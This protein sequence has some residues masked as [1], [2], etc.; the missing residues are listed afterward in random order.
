MQVRL[1]RGRLWTDADLNP[2]ATP[3]VI[4]TKQM[5]DAVWPGRDPLE[6]CLIVDD[7]ACAPVVGVIANFKRQQLREAPFM[8]Y[9]WPMGVGGDEPP[10]SPQI[11]VRMRGDF[12]RAEPLIRRLLLEIDPNQPYTTIVPYEQWVDPKARSWRLGASVLTAFGA[13]SLLLA[14]VGVYAVLSYVVASRTREIGVRAALGASPR[15]V[16][17]TV[18]V[19]GLLASLAGAGLG[20]ALALAMGAKVE[21]LLFN[22]S[23]RDPL[24]FGVAIGAVLLISLAATVLPGLRASRVDPLVALR[25]E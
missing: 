1:L 17:R 11:L 3:T 9:F 20:S 10:G 19:R 8:A 16:M 25:A 14:A 5:A 2:D 6:Q 21:G 18:V 7:R 4:I 13:L 15:D 24:A 22:I 12:G 23:P